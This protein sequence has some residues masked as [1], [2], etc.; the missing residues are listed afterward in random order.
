VRTHV[1]N[2]L[3]IA[4]VALAAYAVQ[5]P[6]TASAQTTPTPTAPT[7]IS[8][9]GSRVDGEI[10]GIVGLGMI[11]VDIGLI[12]PPMI[13]LHD[14]GWAYGV[15]PVV[16]GGGFAAAGVALTSHVD[17]GVNI[18]FLATGLGLF[19]PALVGTLAWK[20][21]KEKEA[22]EAQ[23]GLMR[24]GRLQLNSPGV[25]AAPVYTPEERSR[26]GVAQR[27]STRFTLLSGTF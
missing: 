9:H 3:A 24:F 8:T 23:R 19:I 26:Y 4:V 13:G 25:G 20:S 15:F 17:R 5:A 2:A 11:G 18:A 7:I 22:M 6:S 16:L 27:M 1:L 21:N 10:A 14:Q 12:L